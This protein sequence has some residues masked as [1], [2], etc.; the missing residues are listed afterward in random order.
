MPRLIQRRL[1]ANVTANK[2]IVGQRR[3]SAARQ[4]LGRDRRM[5]ITPQGRHPVQDQGTA[6]TPKP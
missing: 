2:D 1:R 5:V 3:E 6:I 4:S